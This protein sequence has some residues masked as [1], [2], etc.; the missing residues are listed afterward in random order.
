MSFAQNTPIQFVPGI[1]WRTAQVMHDLGIHTVGHLDHI[2]ENILIELFGPS[3]RSILNLIGRVAPTKHVG[4]TPDDA[5]PEQYQT[6]PK[7]SFTK[8]LRI[9]T[10]V[11]SL[12]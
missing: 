8:R 4:P 10:R 12:L 7:T 11:M 9:A 2:P 5:A 1:G 3:I 6:K